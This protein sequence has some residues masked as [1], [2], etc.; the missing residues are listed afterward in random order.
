MADLRSVGLSGGCPR[1]D[2]PKAMLMLAEAIPIN[3]LVITAHKSESSGR[4][5]PMPDTATLE[6]GRQSNSQR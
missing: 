6:M 4:I 3:R 5:L 1:Q 2:H